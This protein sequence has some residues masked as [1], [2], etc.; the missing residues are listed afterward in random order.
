[1]GGWKTKLRASDLD[2]AARLEMVCRKC[3]QVRYLTRDDIEARGPR[4][5]QLYLDEIEARAR[6]RVF[7]CG[8]TMRMAYIRK[9]DTSGFIGGL[10]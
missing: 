4:A 8:G 2:P 1:M 6:C 10:A 7:G 9:H 3:D 5:M